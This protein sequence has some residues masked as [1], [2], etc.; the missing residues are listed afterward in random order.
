MHAHVSEY[1][2]RLLDI[3]RELCQ[4]L[5][6]RN[7]SPFFV[8]WETIDSRRKGQVE[9][10]VD[11]C[12]LERN[13]LTLSGKMRDV[14][15]PDEW[16]PIIA[17]SLIFSKKFRTR[18]FEAVVLSFTLFLLL[19]ILLFVEL[20]VLLPQPYTTI[21]RSGVSVT[22]PIGYYIAVPLDLALVPL[23]TV[24]VALVYARRLRVQAD[25]EAADIVSATTFIAT[26]R[27]IMDSKLQS[28][29]R[30]GIFGLFEFVPLLPNL[31]GRILNLQTY[32]SKMKSR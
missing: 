7:Y 17:S 13:C 4:G 10:P 23:G 15:E 21:T 5:G 3:T 6:I 29:D 25:R 18:V 2:Q 28:G 19:A 9:F 30:R 12:L 31:P 32:F 16:R 24:I 20:R 1:D 27:K 22:N 14:L 8:S 26:L 11:E